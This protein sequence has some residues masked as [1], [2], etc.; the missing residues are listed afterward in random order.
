[1]TGVSNTSRV[2]RV[3]LGRRTGA[4]LLDLTIG[5]MLAVVTV[6]AVVSS[7]TSGYSLNRANRERGLALGVAE[8]VLERLRSETFDEI[9]A[10]FDQ[11]IVDDPASGSSPGAGFA[12]QGLT[13]LEGDAD[14]LPGEIAFPGD[15]STLREDQVDRE[16]GT[17]LDLDGD[18]AIDAL[19]HATDY[20]LLPVRV[21]VVWSGAS[22]AQ[23]VDLVTTLG[24]R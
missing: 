7:L 21:S 12:V 22:G 2:G 5:V 23:R 18:G 13:A 6:G 16:L 3:R 1:M 9:F 24:G 8:G 4:T 11:T 19:D 10:R 20:R 14:G 15:G 17:P